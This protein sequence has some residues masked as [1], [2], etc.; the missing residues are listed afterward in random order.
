MAAGLTFF[1]AFIEISLS[2]IVLEISVKNML[3]GYSILLKISYQSL[4]I[5]H[6]NNFSQLIV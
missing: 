3:S 4:R 5:Y 1:V 6:V 2:N